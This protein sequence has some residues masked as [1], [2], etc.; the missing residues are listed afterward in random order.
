MIGYDLTVYQ[1]HRLGIKQT[2]K[3]VN[4][5]NNQTDRQTDRQT[6]KQAFV[7][8]NLYQLSGNILKLFIFIL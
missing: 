8:V 7:C 3:P 6:D 2:N 5:S 1:H 4:H